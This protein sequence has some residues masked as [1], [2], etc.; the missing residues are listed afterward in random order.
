MD[1]RETGRSSGRNNNLTSTL[2]EFIAAFY[3]VVYSQIVGCSAMHN[4]QGCRG[5]G[6]PWMDISMDMYISLHCALSI[7]APCI[8]IVPVC[9]GRT[10]GR[11]ARGRA[12]SVTT[13]TRNCVHRSTPNWVR[14]CR[15]S[16]W[17]YFGGPAPPG[18][19]SA[20]GRK[21]LDPS[22]YSQ[23]AVYASL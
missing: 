8:V 23:R 14:R 18:T 21:F 11:R 10:G 17:L 13:I 1:W 15:H 20:A 6:Y 3:D 2:R 22:Y 4:T 16:S 5:Y 12:V 9:G 7:A 19:G